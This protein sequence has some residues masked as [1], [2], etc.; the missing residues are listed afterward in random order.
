MSAKSHSS[1]AA[2][3]EEGAGGRG[4]FIFSGVTVISQCETLCEVAVP[5]WRL[6]AARLSGGRCDRYPPPR[7]QT[8]DEYVSWGL[9]VKWKPSNLGFRQS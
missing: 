5:L 3:D 6:P 7:Q 2:E 9:K 4:V 8:I 1:H